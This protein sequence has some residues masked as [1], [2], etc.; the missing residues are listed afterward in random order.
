VN[1]Q[2]DQIF[3]LNDTG[4]RI[5]E[6]I[7][8][9]QSVESIPAILAAEFDVD[10]AVAASETRRLLEALHQAGLLES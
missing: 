3:E 5:W 4:A 7:V 9:G 10:V 6:L 1:L 2:T 8:S